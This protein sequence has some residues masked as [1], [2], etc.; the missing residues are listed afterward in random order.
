MIDVPAKL[1]TLLTPVEA[2]SDP[3]E[4]S[5]IEMQ[6]ATQSQEMQSHFDAQIQQIEMQRATQLQERQSQFD[7][8]I[9]QIEMQRATQLQEMQSQFDAQARQDKNQIE[10]LK[11]QMAERDTENREV[12]EN[13]FNTQQHQVELEKANL[14]KIYE[15]EERKLKQRLNQQF[16]QEKEI[17]QQQY[18]AE[19]GILNAERQE[20]QKN[21]TTDKEVEQLK[22]ELNE[23]RN[24]L[25]RERTDLV[26]RLQS[27]NIASD[28]SAASSLLSNEERLRTSERHL[29]QI[30]E[31]VQSLSA[32]VHDEKAYQTTRGVRFSTHD[33]ELPKRKRFSN[34]NVGDQSS[35]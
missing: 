32:K 18:N 25:Q 19:V 2:I 24:L 6:R 23:S 35:L 21:K 22:T 5:Q 15:E 34:T 30:K 1:K 12:I 27:L 33:G 29:E 20:I 8:Q 10:R 7:A 31:L 4:N 9:Q 11:Q 14:N 16:E 13:I 26:S 3:A 17:L 28:D